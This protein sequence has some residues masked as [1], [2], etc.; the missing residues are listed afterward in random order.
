MEFAVPALSRRRHSE[1]IRVRLEQRIFG[2]EMREL[3]PTCHR[4]RAAMC[5]SS[6]VMTV[7]I[8]QSRNTSKCRRP[9]NHHRP[10][11]PSCVRRL[12]ISLTAPMALPP[13]AAP[14]FA[15]DGGIEVSPYHWW[16]GRRVSCAVISLRAANAFERNEIPVCFDGIAVVENYNWQ[17]DQAG[18]RLPL[19]VRIAR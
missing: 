13:N 10:T 17:R 2:A 16:I 7:L 6:N 12:K 8:G 11:P 9:S 15:G 4:S 1:R 18:V 3:P 14:E 19:V 5:K